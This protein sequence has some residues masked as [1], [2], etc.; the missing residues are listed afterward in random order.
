[1]HL[2]CDMKAGEL[3]IRDVA[4]ADPDELVVDAARRM[5]GFDVGDLIV[6]D[7]CSGSE[8]RPIGIVTDRDL[9]VEVLA[10][11]ERTAGSTR[12]ADVMHGELVT[13]NEDDDVEVI[14][15]KMRTHGIR[16]IPIVDRLGGLQ[17][18]LSVDD[19]VGWIREQLHTATRLLEKQGQGPLARQ[20][21][22]ARGK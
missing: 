8:P 5:A 4:T 15:E 21:A 3:C 6:V 13:A 2:G 1:M 7:G 20:G 18:V 11:P 10:H 9:V 12:V 16:R 19:I 22:V 17:G 14:A